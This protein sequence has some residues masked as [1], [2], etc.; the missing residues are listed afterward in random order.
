MDPIAVY[1][2][3]LFIEHETGDHPEC[4][5]RLLVAKPVLEKSGLDLEWKTPE[6][7]PVE[8]VARVHDRAYIDTVKQIADGGGGQLD[9]DT[10]ISPRSYDAALLAAGAGMMA[11]E[12][13][14]ADGQRAFM[15]VRPPG[16]HACR[17]RGMGFCLFNNIAIAAKYALEELGLER[18]LIVDWDVHHGNG[19]QAA[20][21]DDPRVLFVS[22]H[23]AGHYPGTGLARDLGSGEGAGY[24]I[25]VPLQYGCG[26]GAVRLTFETLVEPLA[27]VFRPQLILVSAGYD[28]QEGDPLGGLRFSEQ[29]FQ[30]MAAYL[31]H[32]GEEIEAAGPLVF[33]EGGYVPDMVAASIVATLKGLQGEAPPFDPVATADEQADVRET[34]EE[35]KPYWKS[36]FQR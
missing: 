18:I 31:V 6:P 15:L 19:T 7:A 17:S 35:V 24:T 13:S 33:L 25:N 8:A 21:H 36:V 16:H 5:E 23:L 32:L 30:W 3:P 27:R 22:T 12:R 29:A 1:Y 4:K 34:L 10:L 28:P 9:W 14:L 26:D 2:H 11:V 20:F